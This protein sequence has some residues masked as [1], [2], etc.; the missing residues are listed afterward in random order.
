MA[1]GS[2][3]GHIAIWNLEERKLQSQMRNAHTGSVTGMAFLHGEPILIT[4]SP[5][6]NLKVG[7]PLLLSYRE[8]CAW[9]KILMLGC[10][11]SCRGISE[12]AVSKVNLI[13]LHLHIKT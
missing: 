2:P 6:N 13:T 7:G 12:L 3:V 4:N 10:T 5:D 9:T 8:D 11:Y 1:T